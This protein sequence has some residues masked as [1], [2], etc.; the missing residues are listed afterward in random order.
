MSKHFLRFWPAPP[1]RT[2]SAQWRLAFFRAWTAHSALSL[3]FDLDIPK[4]KSCFSTILRSTFLN[5]S[6]IFLP[7]N[8][9]VLQLQFM[10]ILLNGSLIQSR[11]HS[12]FN[13][14]KMSS[15]TSPNYHTTAVRFF[16]WNAVFGCHETQP[17]LP[18]KND[19][20]NSSVHKTL[21]SS[22]SRMWGKLLWNDFYFSMNPILCPMSFIG[23]ETRK[24]ISM[25]LWV[26]LTSG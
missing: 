22:A 26:S 20:F 14:G 21:L 4:E 3:D 6:I 15:K 23:Q 10:D 13:N 16:L 9:T 7:H 17:F 24:D 11:I 2:T 8:P 19:S 1:R 18:S 12:S 5:V 25:L